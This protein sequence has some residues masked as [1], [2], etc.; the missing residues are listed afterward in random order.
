[1]ETIK[2]LGGSEVQVDLS[3]PSWC[4]SC[5]NE[6]YW[7]KTKSG[8]NTPISKTEQGFY[9]SHFA[10]CPFAKKYRKKR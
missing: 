4:G 3:K 8:K 2:L 1:M 5:A 9:E 10:N 7:A 6:I